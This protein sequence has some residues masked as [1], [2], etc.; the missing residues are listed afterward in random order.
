[1]LEDHYLSAVPLL[2]I[3]YI[4][5]YPPYLEAVSS[6]RNPLMPHA[7]VTTNHL[8]WISFFLGPNAFLV[9]WS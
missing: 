7:V 1:M 2:L 9:I 5:G 4:R 8:T 3:K 6:I